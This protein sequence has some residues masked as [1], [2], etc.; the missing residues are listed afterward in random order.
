MT[1]ARVASVLAPFAGAGAVPLPA[2]AASIESAWPVRLNQP[3]RSQLVAEGLLCRLP[4]RGRGGS[5]C[6]SPGDAYELACAAY[7]AS[8]L[9]TSIRS[10]LSGARN[11]G[12]RP[13]DLIP[14]NVGQ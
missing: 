7:V 4:A 3:M 2:L 8:A 10:V 1:V 11:L 5:H 12:C 6:L 14:D 9:G 13:S